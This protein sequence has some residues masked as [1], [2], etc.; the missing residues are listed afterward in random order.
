MK[1][2]KKSLSTLAFWFVIV[3]FA[4]N[5]WAARFVD[6]GDGT[7]TDNK[8]R[9]VWQQEPAW[10]TY[11]WAKAS[12]YCRDLQSGGYSDW[13]LPVVT[14]S[15]TL[16]DYTRHGPALNPVFEARG[17]E[18]ASTTSVKDNKMAWSLDPYNGWVGLRAKDSYFTNVRCVRGKTTLPLDPSSHLKILTKNSI[19]D[20]L[21][22]LVWQRSDDGK[23]RTWQQA[24]QYCRNMALDGKKNW[25]LPTIVELQTIVDYKAHHPAISKEFFQCRSDVYWSSS[26]EVGY[27][28]TWF[29]SFEDGGAS[30]YMGSTPSFVRCVRNE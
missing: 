18:W 22:H 13:R 16:V 12:T 25:R 10:S 28:N 14:E 1:F 3:A 7:V 8:T 11:T 6:N 17:I 23:R 5:S 30:Y 2:R 29:V 4:G 20:T 9:L 26:E 24:A 27:K 19:K 15:K 21:H